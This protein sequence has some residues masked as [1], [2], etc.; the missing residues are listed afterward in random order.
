MATINVKNSEF[1]KLVVQDGI[2]V[3]RQPGA[4]RA[5]QFEELVQEVIALDLD[6]I[7]TEIVKEKD[8]NSNW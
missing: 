8:A 1:E 3:F 4:L 5:S 6:S 7:Q 2:L